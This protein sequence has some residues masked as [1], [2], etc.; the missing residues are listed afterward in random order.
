MTFVLEDCE[1]VALKHSIE[2]PI[3]LNFVNFFAIF[4]PRVLS[5]IDDLVL[6]CEDIVENPI[7]HV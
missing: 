7:R 2:K 6:I 4:Y 5:N 3:L 1:N